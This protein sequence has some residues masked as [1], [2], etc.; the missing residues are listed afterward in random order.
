[1]GTRADF[2]IKQENI[3][4]IEYCGS[5]AWDGYE[6]DGVEEAK[7]IVDFRRKLKEFAEQ[8]DDFTHPTEGWPWPW[9]NS[10]LTDEIWVFIANKRGKGKVWRAFE[11][12]GDYEDITTPLIFAPWDKQPEFNEDKDEYEKPKKS[13]EIYMPDMSELKNVA[14]GKKSGLIAISVGS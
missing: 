4:K 8:R 3:D 9:L 6:I 5:I 11:K 7:S 13:M 2:Y 10:K 14:I 1:M 12:V